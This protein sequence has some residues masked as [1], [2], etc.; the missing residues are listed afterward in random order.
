MDAATQNGDLR[1]HAVAELRVLI[2]DDHP[3]FAEA[4]TL[5]LEA[6]QR[7]EVV[8]HARN[9]REAIE[10]ATGLRPD[11]ILMDLDMPVVDGIE[12]TRSVRE[13]SPASRVVIVTAS[14]SPD[15]ERLARDAGAAGYLRK[16]CYASDLFNAIFAVGRLAKPHQIGLVE[17]PA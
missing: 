3:L 5:T 9:G 17:S 1:S 11:V 7:L 6:D 16:G 8:G 2:A 15:D 10:L 4:L 14:T 12:A 13:V